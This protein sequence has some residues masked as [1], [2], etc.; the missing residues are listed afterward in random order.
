[1]RCTLALLAPNLPIPA[2]PTLPPLALGAIDV[3]LADGGSDAEVEPSCRA[4][5]AGETRVEAGGNCAAFFFKALENEGVF[6]AA[7]SLSTF[8]SAA[9]TLAAFSRKLLWRQHASY[10]QLLL[11]LQPAEPDLPRSF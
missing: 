4:P 9:S 7:L 11:L 6:F 10:L 5:G 2:P 3:D 8:C 1:M